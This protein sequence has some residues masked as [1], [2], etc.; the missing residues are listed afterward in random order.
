M[1]LATGD[2]MSA[3]ETENIPLIDCLMRKISAPLDAARQTSLSIWALKTTMVLDVINPKNRGHFY[4]RAE[5]E[6]LHLNRTI[7]EQSYVWIGAYSRSGLSADGTDSSLNLPDVPK[8]AKASVSTFII[9]Y[10]AIQVVTIH[11]EP[12]HKNAPIEDVVLKAG[13]WDKLLLNIWP[14]GTRAVTWPP[15]LSFTHS[16]PLSIARLMDRWRIGKSV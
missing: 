2:G 9:G 15:P 10:L 16:G 7:P 13:P 8:A 6:G 1:S 3:L 11:N 4:T 14:V 5:C 12:E